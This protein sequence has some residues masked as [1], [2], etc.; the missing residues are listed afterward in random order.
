V[1]DEN[2]HAPGGTYASE[3]LTK[4]LEEI[5]DR[6]LNRKIHNF[7]HTTFNGFIQ[8]A[9][10]DDHAIFEQVIVL[11]R[12]DRCSK[13]KFHPRCDSLI[14]STITGVQRDWVRNNRKRTHDDQE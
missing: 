13:V 12:K 6:K 4:N 5:G 3:I 10:I 2:L 8:I 1:E 9:G 14:R 11:Y 7:L